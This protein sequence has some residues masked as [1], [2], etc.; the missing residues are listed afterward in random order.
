MFCVLCFMFQVSHSDGKS[1]PSGGNLGVASVVFIMARDYI[2]N[3]V[4]LPAIKIHSFL[5]P[6]VIRSDVFGLLG[7]LMNLFGKKKW[8]KC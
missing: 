3:K 6:L 4:Y 8:V 5:S 1:F 7:G 2:Y